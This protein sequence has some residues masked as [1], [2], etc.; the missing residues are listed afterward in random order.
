MWAAVYETLCIVYVAIL[1]STT[2]RGRFTRVAEIEKYETAA[3]GRVA[4]TGTDDVCEA[5]FVVCEDVV[6][7]AVGE[8][9][10]ETC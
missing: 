8:G 3:A 5:C 9:A 6:G 10:V 1:A 2:R 4:R 7:A